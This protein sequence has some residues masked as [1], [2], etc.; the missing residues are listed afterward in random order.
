VT[1]GITEFDQKLSAVKPKILLCQ[2]CNK[3]RNKNHE[4]W[5]HKSLPTFPV[6]CH[7]LNSSRATRTGLSRTLLQ[8]S[9]RVEMV[10]VRDF[11]HREVSVKVGVMEF[12]LCWSVMREHL[13]EIEFSLRCS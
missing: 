8:T 11:L 9:Q 2:L 10:C 12:G 4:S 1:G 3:V 6:H 13:L 7:R 5:R